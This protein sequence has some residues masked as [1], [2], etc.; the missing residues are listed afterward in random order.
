MWRLVL[1]RIVSAVVTL[2]LVAVLVF[3][4]TQALPG[5][6]AR[7]ALGQS[8][9]PQRLAALRQQLHLDEPATAQFG[10][11]IGDMA[12][13]DL[14]TSL[15]SQRPVS[16]VLSGRVTNSVF[17]V[18][19]AAIIAL[20]LAL[21]LG[22]L[23]AVRRDRAL[24]HAT[25][26]G[27]LAIAALPEFVIGIGLILL[28]ATGVTHLLP[29]VSLLAPGERPWQDPAALVLPVVTLVLAV[30]PYVSRIVRGSL[31]E[32]LEREYVQTAR[33]NGVP[34]RTVILRH[35]LPN[36]VAPAIQASALSLAYMTGGVV[37][38]EYVFQYPGIGSALVDAVN[39]R[40]VPVVQALVLF[41]GA[42]YVGLNLLAD[43]LVIAVTPKL[44]TGRSSTM[45]RAGAPLEA[46]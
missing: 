15:A 7:A 22:V 23:G 16:Q 21:A 26:V 45:P 41:A 1:W 28:L 33:L 19:L 29:P 37:V 24:D 44:R 40:D 32:V 5:D 35:A 25:T 6:A 38:V 10:H 8:A 9:T 34:E 20:P 36:A 30:I 46:A 11:W 39:G 14:G 13:G 4:A 17:L 2:A 18:L 43:L 12:R 27:L 42:V 3:A 31:I